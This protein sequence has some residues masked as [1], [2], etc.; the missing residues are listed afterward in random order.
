MKINCSA[1]DNRVW[2]WVVTS[3]ASLIFQELFYGVTWT[4]WEDTGCPGYGRHLKIGA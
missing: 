4:S 3:V 1:L 2:G